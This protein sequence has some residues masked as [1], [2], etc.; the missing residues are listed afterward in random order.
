MEDFRLKVFYSVAKNQSFTR[1][2][3]ELFI[4]QPAVTKHIKLLEESLETRLFERRGSMVGVTPAGEVLFKYATEIFNLYQEV[5]FELAALKK[6]NKGNFKL[7]AS[8]TISHYL[9]SPILAS[10]YEKFP[11]VEL[12]LLNG[13]TE[14]IENAVL[15]KKVDLGIVE[16]K[17]HHSDLKYLDFTEDELVAVVHA[18]SKY[19]KLNQITLKEL[20][21]IP[22]VLRERGSGTLD[23]IESSLKEH[24]IKLGSLPII[25]HLGGTESI[26]SFL[27]H[28]NSLSFISIKAIHREVMSN[29]LKIIAIQDFKIKRKF[30]FIHLHGQPEGLSNTFIRFAMRQY[31]PS[32]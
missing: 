2:A 25:M 31:G 23:V 28:S 18:K 5:Q 14:S 8:T 20:T 21:E 30:S 4:S 32:I 6:L 24:G 12:S 15:N 22:M 26:K 7:G 11:Q 27:E 9:I 19:S 29:E 3:S 10:F 13:N 1:A 17:R 16:G